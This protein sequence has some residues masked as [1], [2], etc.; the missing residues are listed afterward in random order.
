M[1]AQYRNGFTLVE[2]LV[3]IAIIGI[4]MAMMLPA[5]QWARED[6]ATGVLREQSEA[7]RPGDARLHRFAPGLSAEQHQP[8]GPGGMDR[9][10]PINPHP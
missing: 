5:V 1:A 9:E 6:L 4:L 3:V 2:L 10:A 7:D 8:G